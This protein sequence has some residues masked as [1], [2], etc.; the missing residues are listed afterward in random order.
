MNRLSAIAILAALSAAACSGS[1]ST[2]PTTGSPTKPTFTA[3]LKPSNEVPPVTNAEASG[4]G[5]VTI[6]FDVTR[7]GA[8][9]ITAATATFVV[10]LTGFPPGT[11][12]TA[13]HI[14]EGPADCACPF[15]INTNITSGANVLTNGSGGFSTSTAAD[16][17]VAQAV[18]NNP[19]AYYF[20]VHSTLNGGG[21]ARGPL[22]K[23]P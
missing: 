21:F 16:P 3:T 7:D 19:A 17:A 1:S 15:R 23:V 4:N 6:T 14:H 22:V 18:I 13:A 8:G 20:N 11:T 9:N 12:I 2:S 10:N 5:N